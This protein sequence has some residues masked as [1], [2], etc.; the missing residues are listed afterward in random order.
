MT[1]SIIIP[2]YWHS[3]ALVDL[4]RRCLETLLGFD[5]PDEIIVVDDGSPPLS[6][7]HRLPKGIK[8]IKRGVNG[9]YAAAVNTGLKEASGDILIVCNNDIEFIQPAW[10]EQLLLPLEEGFDISSIRTTDADGWDVEERIEEGAKFG[11][12]YALKRKVYDRIGGLDE[13]FGNY[14]E[15]LDFHKRAED[16]GFKVG[17]NHNGIVQHIGKATFKEVD[18]EDRFYQVARKLFKEKHG[19]VW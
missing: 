18:P 7:S 5:H 4:T 10:L 8:R 1:T 16:A 15:D 14:F 6:G 11:S 2:C 3:V 19:S 12:I 17:K 9:G 13:S